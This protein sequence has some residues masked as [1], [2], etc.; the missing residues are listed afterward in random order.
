VEV[1]IPVPL[2]RR[3]FYNQNV[4]GL[5]SCVGHSGCYIGSHTEGGLLD[6]KW[7]WERAKARDGIPETNPG[8]NNGTTLRAGYEVRRREGLRR[9]V[10]DARQGRYV[11]Q[12]PDPALRLASYW[13][14]TT[15]EGIRAAVAAG[16][17]VQL[18]I[19]WYRGDSRPIEKAGASWVNP[20][21]GPLEGGHAIVVRRS[22]DR[23]EA[24]GLAQTWGLGYGDNGYVLIP[25]REVERRLAED[26][27]AG[28]IVDVGQTP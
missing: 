17:I 18:G 27:E 5:S 12:E 20:N 19:N 25:M 7:L 10:W 28:V 15:V 16:F 26:G 11:S 6:A 1:A 2:S 23:L 24:F 3:R 22:S 4:E 13:W 8:D 14:A 9:V 21:R